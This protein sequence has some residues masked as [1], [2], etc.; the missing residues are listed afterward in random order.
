MNNKIISILETKDVNPTAVRIVVL[1]LFFRHKHALSL[2]D[3]EEK[4]PWSDKASLFRTLKTFEQHEILHKI[5]D[6]HKAAKYALSVEH[7]DEHHHL[8][9]PHFHCVKCHKTICLDPQKLHFSTVPKGFQITDYSL[10][11]KG[12]C[13]DCV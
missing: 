4:L 1:E 11:I 7:H 3:L 6:G 2:Q 5:D 10:V 12:V 9:H 8:V 13:K